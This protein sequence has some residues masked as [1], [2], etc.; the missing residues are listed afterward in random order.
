MIDLFLANG[1]EEVEALAPL[2]LL[3]RAGLSVTTV[4]IGGTEIVG[5]H[6]ISVKAD[7][8]DWQYHN[9][10]PE[11]IFLPG[12][13]PG[14]LNLANSPTVKKAIQTAHRQNAWIAAICAAPSI[15]GDM[16]LLAGKKAV[17]YPGFESH[18]TDAILSDQT[19]VRDGTI[20]TAAGMGVA[21]ELGFLLV[22]LLCGKE[23]AREL[24]H[25][26]IA[27]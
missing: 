14:T 25:A 27:D 24:R 2:D 3:R 23:K 5:A 18:L 4:G 19:V 16:G 21:L 20:I 17:C 8:P 7:L 11:L 6:G 22:E 15:L 13:M 1:F 26:T 9:P 12:G 10:N